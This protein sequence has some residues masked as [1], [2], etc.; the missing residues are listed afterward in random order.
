M[1][2]CVSPIGAG[3]L[4]ISVERIAGNGNRQYV[5]FRSVRGSFHVHPAILA[6]VSMPAMGIFMTQARRPCKPGC[7]KE[8]TNDKYSKAAARDPQAA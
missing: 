8:T 3:V 7:R 4:G 1:K 5:S 2:T 6:W